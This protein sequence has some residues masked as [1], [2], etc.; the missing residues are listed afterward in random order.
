MQTKKYT[1][2]FD[3]GKATMTDLLGGKGANLAEMSNLGLPVPP[4]FTITTQ[5]CKDYYENNQVLTDVILEQIND[6]LSIIENVCQKKF[7]GENPL[8]VSV[9]SGAAVSMPG[10]MDTV[11]NLGLNDVTVEHLAKLTNNRRFA[12][13]SYRRF[14]QMYANVVLDIESNNFEM[15]IEGLKQN[16]NYEQDIDLTESDLELIIEEFKKIVLLKTNSEF[17]MDCKVQ[18]EK[19]IIAV[20]DSWENERAV[21][22][23]ELNKIPHDLATAV[24]IQSMVY[25]NMG[26]TSGTG[27]LFTRNPSTGERTIF[28][29]YLVNAQ[30]EDVVA[31]IR[32]PQ[33]L[34]ELKKYNSEIFEQLC[35]I[36]IKLENHYKDVQDVEFTVERNQLF[37]LQTRS[38]KR[39]AQAAMKIAVDMFEEGKI[40]K[41]TALTRI[42][43]NQ[44]NQLLHPTFKTDI[45]GQMHPI[46]KGLP[47]SPGAAS[48]MIYFDAK[49]VSKQAST[50]K[51]V[52]L[53]RAETSPE[54]IEGMIAC[55]GILTHTGGMTSHAAVV[56]RGMGK[57]CIVGCQNMH[58]DYENKRLVVGQHTIKEGEYLSIDGSTGHVYIGEIETEMPELSSNFKKIMSWADEYALMSVRANADTKREAEIALSFNAKG[59][60]LCRTEHMFFEK[61]RILYMQEMIISTNKELRSAALAELF[62]FQFNDFYDIF[63]VMKELPVTIRLLDPPLHEFLPKTRQEIEHLSC[64]SNISHEEI[65]KTIAQLHEHNPMLGHRGCRLGVTYPEIYRMQV[66]AIIS[67][68]IKA[69]DDFNISIV[70]EIMIPLV[71]IDVEQAFIREHVEDEISKV[72]RENNTKIEY[73]IGCMIEVPRA[74]LTADEIAKTT[75]FFSFGTNDLTQATFC[76]SRDDISKFINEYYANGIL[77]IDPFVTLDEKGVGRLVEMG[78]NMGRQRNANL[79]IGVCGE[80][81][82]DPASIM[83]FY[84]YG[85]DYVSCSPF[86]IAIAK[87]VIAQAVCL[88]LLKS[89]N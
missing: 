62:P 70:P 75:D 22:Y 58:V 76:Y 88:Q 59:I 79:K 65:E 5:A 86:R 54:D 2:L 34:S 56:A 41:I 74:A 60:G 43:P 52:L 89:R 11:L 33:P 81:A 55:Q 7:G 20:F 15:I 17:P 68:A 47:A 23:R 8:L 37:L 10:M 32:T 77:K 1:Y 87:L 45:I 35:S 51:K 13:D 53:V 19:A 66:R 25:G 14:I 29:E 61:N 9:R 46:S 72:L 30:G 21:L 84:K 78:A 28:G 67:A 42:E 49:T 18:L 12:L 57:T 36:V 80:H 48:G 26:N 73:K 38:A 44:I 16:K 4:G 3:Q 69:N 85:L 82:G 64:H 40:D 71:G 63:S 6:S 39:S 24:N 27:V 31:G 83:L 50:G